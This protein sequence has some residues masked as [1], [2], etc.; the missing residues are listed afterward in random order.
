[1]VLFDTFDGE[2]SAFYRLRLSDPRLETI[3][4]ISNVRRYYG[5]FGPWSGMAPDGSPLLVR[6][7]SNEE[8]YALDLQL[9]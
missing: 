8:V 6:D 4:N 5:Q 1:N 2:T 7:V 3:V 9:P